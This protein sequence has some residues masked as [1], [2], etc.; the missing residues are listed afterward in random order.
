MEL[1]EFARIDYSEVDMGQ[2]E[3]IAPLLAEMCA[4]DIAEVSSPRRFA[5]MAFRF[6]LAPGLAVDDETGWE[7][8]LREE[9]PLLTVTSQPCT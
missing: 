9:D 2:A 1:R 8:Q 3:E 7:E 5:E 6:G 4:V